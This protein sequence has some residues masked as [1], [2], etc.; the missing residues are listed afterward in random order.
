MDDEAITILKD[1]CAQAFDVFEA[2]LQA[3]QA[4]LKTAADRLELECAARLELI[5]ASA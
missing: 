3:A 1:E 5:E 4:K 2:E